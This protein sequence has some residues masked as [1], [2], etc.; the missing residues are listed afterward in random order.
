MIEKFFFSLFR[1]KLE[2]F[3]ICK[4]SGIINLLRENLM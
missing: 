3:R 4:K 2:K 1:Y